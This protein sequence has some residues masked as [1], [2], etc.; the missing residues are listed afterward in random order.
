M[1]VLKLGSSGNEVKRWQHFLIG[2]KF[3]LG[4]ADGIYDEPTNEATKHF[5]SKYKLDPDGRVGNLTFGQ[6]MLLGYPMVVDDGQDK[7][8]TSFPPKPNFSPLT[9]NESRQKLFGKLEFVHE[10]TSDNPENIR[11][12]NH[13]DKEQIVKI[14]IKQLKQIKGSEGVYFH[15]QAA[16]QLIQLF[17]DWESKKLLDK[18]LTWEGAYYPRL[19]RG[20][21]KSLSNHSFGT[22]FDINYAWNKLGVIPALLGQKGSVRELID[23]AHKNGFYWGGHFSRRDGMH[24]EIAKLL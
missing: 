3:F 4:V 2:Q 18:V 11:I 5:Q 22:A 9:S 21:K 24:F 20:S 6:A 7:T 23:V 19:V 10:P 17:N 8:S 16:P 12:T 1:K 13:Y 14:N 15:K